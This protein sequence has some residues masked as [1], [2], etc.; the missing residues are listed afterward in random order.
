MAP[1]Y[2]GM[3]IILALLVVK[4]FQDLIHI[5][6][7]VL[8][9]SEIELIANALNLVDLTLVANLVTMVSMVGY[10]NFV[11]RLLPEAGPLP[12]WLAHI[13]L[14]GLKLKLIASIISI[15]AIDLLKRYLEISDTPRA[16]LVVQTGVFLAFVVAGL[17]LAF[18][19]RFAGHE[20]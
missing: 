19:D 12:G 13:D 3:A 17:L 7:H 5:V 2:L 20:K 4:F 16:D 14:S 1:V 11:G 18:M 6:P 9:M 8:E 10:E 15:A